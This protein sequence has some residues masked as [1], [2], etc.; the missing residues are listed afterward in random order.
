[1]RTDLDGI[2]RYKVNLHMHTTL[3]DGTETP[4]DAVRIYREQG[5]DAVALT[6][7]WVYGKEQTIGGTTVL[8]GCEYNT[9]HGDSRKGVYHIVGID[10]KKDP[11]IDPNAT[12]QERIDAIHRVGGYVILAHPAW[13][14]NTPEQIMAL[15]DVDGTEIYNSLS[16][17]RKFRRPDSSL[18][19]DMIGAKKRFYH[20]IGADDTHEY[21]EETCFAFIMV[22]AENASADALMKG[23]RAGRYYAT[24]GPEIHIRR[25][26]D[27]IVVNCS[28]ASEIEFIS[29]LAWADP[30]RIYYGDGLT[31]ARYGIHPDENFVRAE[32][33]DK[34]GKRAWSQIIPIPE[35][36][37]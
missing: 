16:G 32:I 27:E 15:R 34:D 21:G 35:N 6:D 13:S 4:E 25:E 37:L 18:I 14:L 17:V 9:Y 33:R 28:P 3:S 29:N 31:E 11:E 26:G 2:K 7:H 22:E 23:I 20:L 30:I 8:C 10:M 19:I 24:E 5:Y 12:A 36:D 1:M